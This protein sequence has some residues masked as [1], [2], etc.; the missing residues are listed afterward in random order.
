MSIK[1]VNSALSE[2]CKDGAPFTYLVRPVR[3]KL[4]L[5]SIWPGHP[6]CLAR[7]QRGRLERSDS[8]RKQDTSAYELSQWPASTGDFIGLAREGERK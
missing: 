4:A 5:T 2:W 7:Q 3:N 1:S 6:G 8:R